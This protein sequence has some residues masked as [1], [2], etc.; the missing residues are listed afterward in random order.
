MG[1]LSLHAKTPVSLAAHFQLRNLI[2]IPEAFFVQLADAVS[3]LCKALHKLVE[4]PYSRDIDPG[5]ILTL[6][7]S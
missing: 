1:G 6:F 4:K 2:A 5:T 3:H 7:W